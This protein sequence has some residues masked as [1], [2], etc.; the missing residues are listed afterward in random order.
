[1]TEKST[2]TNAI[3]V[4]AIVLGVFG[5]LGGALGVFGL[6]HPTRSAVPNQDPKL[7]ALNAEFQRRIEESQKD[8]R[9]FSLILVPLVLVASGV[10][11]AAGISGLKPGGRSFLRVA[12]CGNAIVDLLGGVMGVVAQFR[13]IGITSWYFRETAGASSLP[14]G[15]SAAMQFAVTG[16]IAMAVIWLLGKIGFYIWA[17]LHLGKPALPQAAQ[18]S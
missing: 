10:L 4:I 6:L 11:I 5:V 7:S 17:V 9:P 18:G 14:R 2:S 12:L 8:L 13:T 1:M 3:C 15:V 16:G